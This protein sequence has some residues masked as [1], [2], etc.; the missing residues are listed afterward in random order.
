MWAKLNSLM[1]RR[2]PTQITI[3]CILLIFLLG[4]INSKAGYELTFSIFYLIPI[5]IISW[6]I[7]RSSGITISIISAVVWG[8]IDVMSGHQYSHI[9]ILFWNTLARLGFFII[10]TQLLSTL[11]IQFQIEKRLSRTDNLTGTLNGSA[12]EDTATKLLG[13]VARYN[14]PT[15]LA[16][17]DVDNFKKINDTLGHLEGNKVL[18]I[19]GGILLNS[20]R[21]TD[22]VGRMGGDEF[23]IL[24]PETSRS[25][26]TFIF[27]RI[28]Q[29]ITN[30]A[31]EYN[32][33][34]STSIG[35]IAVFLK[36]PP[37]VEEAIK[38]ADNLMYRVKNNGKNNILIEEFP[39]NKIPAQ[40]ES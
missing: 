13:I 36:E 11:K 22:C 21:S 26:A 6:Y 33:P 30:K 1:E 4:V 28:R 15:V 32:W 9:V 27:E 35:G 24:L 23:T 29:Q 40:K 2:T 34:I 7:G 20:V 17:I 39:G 14:H 37:T 16:Y 8:S 19:I 38:F 10:T 3:I 31:N 12:F 5:S 18:N 25:D